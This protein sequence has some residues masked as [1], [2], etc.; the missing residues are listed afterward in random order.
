M[1]KRGRVLVTKFKGR[2]NKLLEIAQGFVVYREWAL[3]AMPKLRARKKSFNKNV[4][5]R[6]QVEANFCFNA[7]LHIFRMSRAFIE[8]TRK[9]IHLDEEKFQ[10]NLEKFIKTVDPKES[11]LITNN[12]DRELKNILNL[13]Q[14][15]RKIQEKGD[16]LIK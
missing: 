2:D 12:L 13:Q 1:S 10:E 11:T 14:Q 15:H 6:L 4:Q 7:L 5:I 3:A 16:I 8:N 9:Q